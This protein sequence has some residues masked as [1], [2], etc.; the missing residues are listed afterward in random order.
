MRYAK[1]ILNCKSTILTPDLWL[2]LTMVRHA[3]SSKFCWKPM[4]LGISPDT[5]CTKQLQH[6]PWNLSTD[7]ALC[8]E[9]HCDTQHMG[10]AHKGPEWL[11]VIYWLENVEA[12]KLFF[13]PLGLT[14]ANSY[15][16]TSPF[17]SRMLKILSYNFWVRI[18]G[19]LTSIQ[20]CPQQR[21]NN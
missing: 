10:N 13:K 5:P 18:K 4:Q 11:T 7:P 3:P 12:D 6:K 21:R 15:T 1:F 8:L 16:I 20:P 19:S 14:T 9:Y 2:I 17:S